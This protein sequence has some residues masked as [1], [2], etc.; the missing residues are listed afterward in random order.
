MV[1]KT[2]PLVVE[3][4][5]VKVVDRPIPVPVT[6]TVIKKVYKKN[7]IS[8]LGGMGPTRMSITQ[9]AVNLERGLV[10]GVQYQ[11]MLNDSFSVGVQV[12]SNETVLGPKQFK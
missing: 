9:S 8:A 3:K 2:V 4:E 11:R 1:K 7:R 12:Q 10:L 6:H 5:V